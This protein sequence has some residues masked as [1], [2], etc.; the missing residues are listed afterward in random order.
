MDKSIVS[1]FLT[2]GVDE[3]STDAVITT[4]QALEQEIKD[5][6]RH[7]GIV[8]WSQDDS[9]LDR[10]VTI[11]PQLTRMVKQ[12]LSGFTKF[13]QTSERS[14][15][16]Q[17]SGDFAV[18]TV[19]NALKLCHSIQKHSGGNPFTEETT[20]KNVASSA[21]VPKMPEKTFRSSNRKVNRGFMS[22]EFVE[23]RLLNTSKLSVWDPLKKLKLKAFSNL[24][25]KTKVSVGQKVI[26]LR[27]E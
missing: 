7:G 1:P 18:R 19:T 8:G 20:L 21:L 12:Y 5:L 6:K 15:H 9:G 16:Y 23:E 25:K 13:S 11:S 3:T 4:N 14:E 24:M 22:N 10:L 27:E 2:H 17:L 26:K